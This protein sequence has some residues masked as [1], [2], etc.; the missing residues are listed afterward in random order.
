MRRV[1]YAQGKYP[2]AVAIMLLFCRDLKTIMQRTG[3]VEPG[4]SSRLSSSIRGSTR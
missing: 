2:V 3:H 4:A 1:V